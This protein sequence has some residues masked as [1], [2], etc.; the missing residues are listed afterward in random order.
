MSD[1]KPHPAT[2]FAIHRQ[3]L[4]KWKSEIGKK[5]VYQVMSSDVMPQKETRYR[6]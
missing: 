1:L 3:Q 2:L 5:N 6:L 4:R